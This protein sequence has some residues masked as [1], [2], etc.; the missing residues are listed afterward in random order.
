MQKNSIFTIL[1][2][3]MAYFICMPSFAAAPK[4]EAEPEPIKPEEVLLSPIYMQVKT[5]SKRP[6]A[7]SVSFKINIKDDGFDKVC[8]LVP[9]IVDAL[10]LELSKTVH[11]YDILSGK[12][13]TNFLLNMAKFLRAEF[14]IRPY[15]YSVEAYRKPPDIKGDAKI[16]FSKCNK[17]PAKT[18]R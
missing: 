10:S 13:K 18:V 14:D 5:T 1:F 7:I 4:K 9:D 8:A 2:F 15:I 3:T 11:D 12:K 16:F 17:N 6:K